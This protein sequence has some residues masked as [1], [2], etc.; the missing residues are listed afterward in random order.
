V[1]L[2]LVVV[3][4]DLGL[5]EEDLGGLME[6]LNFPEVLGLVFSMVLGQSLILAWLLLTL[7]VV[8]GLV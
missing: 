4:L 5:E 2:D 8:Q 1:G 6:D 7:E 3:G